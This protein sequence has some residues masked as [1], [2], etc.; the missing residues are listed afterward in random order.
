[1]KVDLKAIFDE[2]DAITGQFP[3]ALL[4]KSMSAVELVEAEEEIKQS[5]NALYR[6]PLTGKNEQDRKAEIETRRQLSERCRLAEEA[7]VKARRNE[8]VQS[9]EADALKL[10][11]RAVEAKA[12]MIASA[13]GASVNNDE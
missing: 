1:M 3:E 10:R 8:A 4:K 11:M 13:I 9:V 6:E 2:L 5:V 12:T 7:L